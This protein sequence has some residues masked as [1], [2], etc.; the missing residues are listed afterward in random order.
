MPPIFNDEVEY[1]CDIEE[2]EINSW[3]ED[4]TSFEVSCL[5][6]IYLE[7][8]IDRSYN[9][10]VEHLGSHAFAM[11]LNL[12]IHHYYT[13]PCGDYQSE[14]KK[15]FNFLIN[16]GKICE[17]PLSNSHFEGFHTLFQKAKHVLW[18]FIKFLGKSMVLLS[19]P[20]IKKSNRVFVDY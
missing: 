5:Y 11:N 15:R 14:A 7:S 13:D 2:E 16:F 8:H 6:F 12:M 20:L 9:K 4:I 1:D 17:D 3:C 10:H 19:N 18:F